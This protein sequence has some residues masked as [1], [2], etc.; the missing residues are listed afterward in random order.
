MYPEYKTRKF[1]LTGESYGGKYIPLF[2]THII[3]Y[4]KAHEGE[5]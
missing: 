5:F 1:Y 4:N 3:N 2:A